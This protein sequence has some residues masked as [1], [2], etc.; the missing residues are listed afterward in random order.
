MPRQEWAVGF[1]LRVVARKTAPLGVAAP[2]G[3]DLVLIAQGSVI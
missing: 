2:S 1:V 3:F